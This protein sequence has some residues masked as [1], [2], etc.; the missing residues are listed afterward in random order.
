MTY[1]ERDLLYNEKLGGTIQQKLVSGDESNETTRLQNKPVKLQPSWEENNL[2]DAELNFKNLTMDEASLQ[3]CTP[4]DKY[5]FVYII[6]LIHGIATLLP[7]NMFINAISYFIEH[8][9]AKDNIGFDFPYVSNFMQILTFCSQVPNVI[10]NWFNIFVPLKGDLTLRIMWSIAINIML[11]IITVALAMVNTSQWPYEFFYITML[12]VVILNMANG[13]YQNTVYGMAAKLPPKYIGAVIL[14][15]NICGTFITIV[16]IA[17]NYISA[18]KKMAAIWYFITALFV[19]LIGFD[20][21]FALP[22]N[23][24]YRHYDLKEKKQQEQRKTVDN[25]IERPPYLY[26]L[27]KAWPQMYNVFI[28]IFATLAVFPSI[29]AAIKVSDKNFFIQE[30][31][32]YTQVLCFLTFNVFAV[33]GNILTNVYIWPSKK[34]LWIPTTLR[35]LYIPF[36]L[37]CNYQ[38]PHE[39]TRVLPVFITNDYVYWA[40]AATMAFTSG[41]FSSVAMMYT[42][43]TVES[44][45]ASVAGMFAGASLISGIFGGILISFLWPWFITHV[46]W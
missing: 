42:P 44:Q 8:K 12:S 7:W 15:N 23:R 17:S 33:L 36:Y 24:Y 37:F 27:K 39:I 10:F 6:F 45:Y 32:L 41:Y 2:S 29:H 21:Y 11:F 40:V 43:S 18:S 19:L 5:S 13:V 9:L 1:R 25:T 30:K 3:I 38:P 26:I 28:T 22:L 35:L 14:G 31:F 20:T 4:P 34:Y 46:G 16:C